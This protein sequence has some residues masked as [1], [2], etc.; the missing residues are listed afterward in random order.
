MNERELCLI[1]KILPKYITVNN[2]RMSLHFL[3]LFIV[4]VTPHKIPLSRGSFSEREVVFFSIWVFFDKHSRITGLQG[5]EEGIYLS[6]HYHFY[7]L[8]KHLEISRAI[9]AESS[10]LNIASSRTMLLI[11]D[12]YLCIY[13]FSNSLLSIHFLQS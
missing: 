13:F 7:T 12:V 2:L 6:P 8:H 9:T 10:T 5:K 1:T 4:F 11:R 3:N